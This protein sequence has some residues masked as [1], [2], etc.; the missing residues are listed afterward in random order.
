[1]IFQLYDTSRCPCSQCEELY[2]Q[3]NDEKNLSN[4]QPKYSLVKYCF[5]GK[6]KLFC[7]PFYINDYFFNQEAV[8]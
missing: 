5:T 6:V 4:C 3:Y 7:Y 8:R 2:T 1:M